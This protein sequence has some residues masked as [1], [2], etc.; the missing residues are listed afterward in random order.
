M[1]HAPSNRIHA[2]S[3]YAYEEYLA[4]EAGIMPGHLIKLEANNRVHRHDVPEGR[5]ERMFAMEDQHQGKTIDDAYAIG[6]LVACILP[7]IGSE[8]IAWLA[9]NEVVS[10]GDHLVSNGDGCLRREDQGSG[11]E[12]THIVAIAMESVDNLNDSATTN[13][14]RIRVRVCA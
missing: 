9:D 7:N 4:D 1:A 13:A 5:N 6:T 10:I 8:V 2:K 12:N 14:S 3:T 11:S